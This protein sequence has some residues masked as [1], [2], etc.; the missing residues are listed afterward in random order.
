MKDV[1]VI[2]SSHQPTFLPYLGFWMKCARSDIM[3]LTCLYDQF[4]KG[5]YNHRVK[6][7]TDSNNRWLTLPVGNKGLHSPCNEIKLK[8]ELLP[9][10]YNILEGWYRDYPYWDN[11][12]D[13]LKTIFCDYTYEY[14]IELNLKLLLWIRD[15]LDIKT[16]FS[17]DYNKNIEITDPTKKLV[18]RVAKLSGTIY[19]SGIGGRNYLKES[20][21]LMNDINVIY[22]DD[23]SLVEVEDMNSVSILSI[24]MK[25]GTNYTRNIINKDVVLS[26]RMIK[27]KNKEC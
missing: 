1:E 10:L 17:V 2:V 8:N 21:F 3:D 16:I 7:G 9:N 6:I 20:E 26:K 18:E 24:L 11:Y 5:A 22:L 23:I 15:L 25:Y 19:L 4:D 27:Y 13:K 14:Y 12:K